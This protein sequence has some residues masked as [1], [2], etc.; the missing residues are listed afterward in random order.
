MQL[1]IIIF[2]AVIPLAAFAGARGEPLA[3]PKTIFRMVESLENSKIDSFTSR[4]SIEGK[5]GTYHLCS[6]ELLGTATRDKESL[7]LAAAF[8]VRS[9]PLGSETPPARG[10]S[11]LVVFHPDFAIASYCRGEVGDCRM[12][13]NK[14]VRG[15]EVL[16]D[17]DKRSVQTRHSGYLID[18]GDLLPYFFSDRI[19]D[20]QWENEEFMKAELKKER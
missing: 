14:L 20:E 7:Y 18:G 17:F 6:V 1:L 2:L 15:D 11:F 13:G 10:H 8:Y 19:T 9:S 12:N 5:A 16:A 3:E 4:L